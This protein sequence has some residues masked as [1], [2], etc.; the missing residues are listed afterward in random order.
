[1]T[2][3]FVFLGII[4]LV[5]LLHRS[6]E[7]KDV[8][9]NNIRHLKQRNVSV[10]DHAAKSNPYLDSQHDYVYKSCRFFYI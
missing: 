1:M 3:A 4:N 6:L 9:G 5:R 8:C 7:S 10:S 2:D